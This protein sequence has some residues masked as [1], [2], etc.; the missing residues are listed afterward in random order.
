MNHNEESLIFSTPQRVPPSQSGSRPMTMDSPN[1]SPIVSDPRP[2]PHRPY[3][4][5]TSTMLAYAQHVSTPLTSSARRMQQRGMLPGIAEE[6][7][8]SGDGVVEGNSNMNQKPFKNG[9]GAG[10]VVGSLAG[11]PILHE[12]PPR[13]VSSSIFTIVGDH[14]STPLGMADIGDDFGLKSLSLR[15]KE[16]T[17]S[18]AYNRGFPI[19]VSQD[20]QGDPDNSLNSISLLDEFNNAEEIPHHSSHQSLLEDPMHLRSDNQN[21]RDA[22]QYEIPAPYSL[23]KSRSK[24]YIAAVPFTDDEE[25][26]EPLDEYYHQMKRRQN[27]KLIEDVQK[28]WSKYVVSSPTQKHL[29]VPLST[30]EVKNHPQETPLK[31]QTGKHAAIHVSPPYSHRASTSKQR[32]NDHDLQHDEY[33]DDM[34][35][36]DLKKIRIALYP[37]TENAKSQKHVRL[38]YDI[39]EEDGEE[40]ESDDAHAQSHSKSRSNNRSRSQSRSPSSDHQQSMSPPS[41]ISTS[42]PV[43]SMYALILDKHQNPVLVPVLNHSET[44]TQTDDTFP[45][46]VEEEG[47]NVNHGDITSLQVDIEGSDEEVSAIY[48]YGDKSA[49]APRNHKKRTSSAASNHLNKVSAAPIT[50]SSSIN[51]DSRFATHDSVLD[52]EISFL[53]GG[54]RGSSDHEMYLH[55]AMKSDVKRVKFDSYSRQ[56]Q[57]TSSFIVNNDDSSTSLQSISFISRPAR[58][59]TLMTEQHRSHHLAQ[60]RFHYIPINPLS[61]FV[62]QSQ[63]TS[64][65]VS[66][67]HQGQYNYISSREH[68]P[69]ISVPMGNDSGFASNNVSGMT[70]FPI[71]PRLPLNADILTPAAMENF[72]QSTTTFGVLNP[73]FSTGGEALIESKD[74]LFTP[75]KS[76]VGTGSLSGKNSGTNTKAWKS[77]LIKRDMTSV[78]HSPQ[79]S[80]Y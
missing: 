46:K 39:H 62:D 76:I 69:F 60:D 21:F 35:E 66:A 18:N 20:P 36:E 51:R 68:R 74:V 11:T 57:N 48:Y 50:L 42:L 34:K 41:A 19:V 3:S 23:R 72:A 77:K 73:S 61:P 56:Q 27:Q 7:S 22:N 75:G 67:V 55:Q 37:N 47:N 80:K 26:R 16:K 38:V 52:A 4:S 24:E 8:N 25:D 31:K 14:N 44:K 43:G 70:Q 54:T 45:H 49:S 29:G 65:S 63:A 58:K 32:Q 79:M 5:G 15:E 1:L 33:V 10:A 78:L 17:R 59:S 2:S 6:T 53:P 40:P 71:L 64:A 12:K 13:Q 9:Q 28:R 30:E